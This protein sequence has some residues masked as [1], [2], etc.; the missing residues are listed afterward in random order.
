M[1][2][3]KIKIKTVSAWSIGITLAFALLFVVVCTQGVKEFR[4]LRNATEQYIVCENAAKQLQDGSDY[5]TEQARLY[6]MTGQT[7]Y[8]DLYFEEAN[9]TRRRENALDDLKEYFDQT[10]TYNSLRNALNSSLEL[11]DTE[12]YSMRLVCEASLTDPDTWPQEIQ[13]ITLSGADSR[14]SSESKYKKARQLISS[15]EYQN[16]RNDITNDVTECMNNLITQ[17][18]NSQGRATSI[19]IDIYRKLIVSIIVLIT[20]MLAMCLMVRH[21]IVTP[22]L[23]YSDSIKHGVIFP[24]IGSAE[25]QNLAETYNKVYEEN[26]ETQRLIRHQ[27]EHDALTGLFNRGS[28]E[29]IMHVYENG[30]TPFALILVDVDVFKTVNDTYGHAVGDIILKKVS[31]LLKSAFRSIDYV[32]RIGGD[33]FAVLMVA[34]TSDLQYTIKDKIKY[35]NEEL[36][37]TEEGIPAVSLS[38]GVAFSDRPNPGDSIFKDAD[39]ALYAVKENGRNGCG[40]YNGT[41]N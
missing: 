8:R 7:K 19:F 24:V 21:L 25:L 37:R 31:G 10:D 32:C 11:M 29:K 2:N 6:T 3:R 20:L 17:T 28:F 15:N 4:V 26:Q 36:A 22:L 34:M 33:E 40:F 41:S 18:R 1:N 14:L 5:L 27:A 35:V 9:V 13:D 38:V 30:D 23:S 16:A 39:K 12:Y